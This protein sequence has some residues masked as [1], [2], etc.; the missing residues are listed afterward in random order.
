MINQQG[1]GN[2]LP[3]QT[4]K[5]LLALPKAKVEGSFLSL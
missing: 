3:R 5:S 4:F 1:E 2:G